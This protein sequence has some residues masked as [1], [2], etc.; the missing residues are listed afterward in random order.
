MLYHSSPQSTDF[1]DM[2]Q[3]V[4]N[5]IINKSF[6]TQM[7]IQNQKKNSMMPRAKWLVDAFNSNVVMW[8]WTIVI[9]N[10][11]FL[12]YK[13]RVNVSILITYVRNYKCCLIFIIQELP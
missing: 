10:E 9:P 11:K 2:K 3:K 6:T 5:S 1:E 12:N 4:P 13:L 7:H 8:S